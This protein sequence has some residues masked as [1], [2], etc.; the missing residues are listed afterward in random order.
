MAW[1]LRR[2]S[3]IYTGTMF[4]IFPQVEDIPGALA[5]S[6]SCA[7]PCALLDSTRESGLSLL[8]VRALRTF[9]RALCASIPCSPTV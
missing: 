5:R 9:F 1:Y 8:H 2:E 6:V 7:V 4:D 3:D